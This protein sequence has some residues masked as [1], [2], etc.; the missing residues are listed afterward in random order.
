M[1]DHA[2]DSLAYATQSQLHYG[3]NTVE[4]KRDY[5]SVIQLILGIDPRKIRHEDFLKK[6]Q[7]LYKQ[8]STGTMTGIRSLM[9]DQIAHQIRPEDLLGSYTINIG[10][11]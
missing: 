7:K 1:L 11:E 9:N 3:L 6:L 2:A 10:D 4:L 5:C 8:R